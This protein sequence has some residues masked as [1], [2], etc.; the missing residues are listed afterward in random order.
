MSRC[1]VVVSVGTRCPDT[2]QLGHCTCLVPRKKAS[3][4]IKGFPPAET[5]PGVPRATW[6]SLEQVK[7]PVQTPQAVMSRDTHVYT[8]CAPVLTWFFQ[9][10]RRSP[11]TEPA[12]LQEPQ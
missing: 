12:A 5:L 4:C 7:Q 8:I 9:V 1:R 3:P 2:T 10:K 6:H 11:V